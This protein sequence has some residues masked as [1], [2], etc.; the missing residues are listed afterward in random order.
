[1]KLIMLCITVALTGCGVGQQV[2]ITQQASSRLA[3]PCAQS[4]ECTARVAAGETIKTCAENLLYDTNHNLVMQST[5]DNGKTWLI[6]NCD[7]TAK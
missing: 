7:S 1:M 3:V 5:W 2:P 4:A 6:G